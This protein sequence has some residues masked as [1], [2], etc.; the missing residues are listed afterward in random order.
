MLKKIGYIMITGIMLFSHLMAETPPI[1]KVSATHFPPFVIA[2]EDTLTG[3][4]IDLLKKISEVS[5]VT[6]SISINESIPEVYNTVKSHQTDI[7]IGGIPFAAEYEDEIDYTYPTFKSGSLI[8]THKNKKTPLFGIYLED[9]FG[10]LFSTNVLKV[11]T[12]LFVLLFLSANMVWFAERKNNPTMFPKEYLKGILE[13]FWWSS[14]TITTVG[15]GDKTPKSL[16]GRLCALVWMFSGIFIISYFTATISSS[17][18][19]DTLNNRYNT[20][21]DLIGKQVGTVKGNPVAHYLRTIGVRVFEFDS[22]ENTYKALDDSLVSSVVFD[23]PILQY[24]VKEDIHDRYVLS[25]TLFKEEYYAFIV[26][27]N[28]PYIESINHAIILLQ[29]NGEYE[30]IYQKWFGNINY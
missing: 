14:V 3:F 16:I 30:R 7:G 11:V 9:F 20:P 28:S 8:L 22:L 21:H 1:L 24:H 10:A 19:L 25:N 23:A 5:H 29:K 6:Y 15:Y 2:Q 26:P 18:T 17:H 13:S 12:I 27:E 4:S